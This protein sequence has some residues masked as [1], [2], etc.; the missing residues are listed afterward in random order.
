M[1]GVLDMPEFIRFM[2]EARGHVTAAERCDTSSSVPHDVNRDPKHE[3]NTVSQNADQ[4]KVDAGSQNAD[5][6]KVDVG[7][8]NANQSKVD[9]GSQNNK[10]LSDEGDR[11]APLNA[12]NKEAPSLSRADVLEQRRAMQRAHEE[13]PL[14]SVYQQ[15]CENEKHG[16]TV[17][18]L[19][20]RSTRPRDMGCRCCQCLMPVF[21]LPSWPWPAPWQ[22]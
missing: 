20:G 14:R 16:I 13:H 3:F 17:H 5:Q 4:S 22:Y 9:A 2:E 7:S 8:Q 21:V 1:G 18:S 10:L 12:L 19:H 15:L 11:K 6:S